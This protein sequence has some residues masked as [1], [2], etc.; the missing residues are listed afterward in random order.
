VPGAGDGMSFSLGWA[1][2]LLGFVAALWAA[3]WLKPAA[4]V[5]VRFCAGAVVAFCLLMSAE[6]IW[7][8]D[9]LPLLSYVEYPW[10]MLQPAAL[11][12]A[13]LI[14]ALGPAFDA[15]PRYRRT[16]L[17][18][19]LALL[20]VPN[21]AHLQ[22]GR[23]A[24]PDLA[25]WT[26]AHMA[27]SGFETT[28]AGEI[29]PKWV[30]IVRGPASP[31]VAQVGGGD[32]EITDRV[33]TPFEWAGRVRAK[34]KSTVQIERTY[35]PGWT[36]QIDGRD[37]TPEPAQLTGRLQFAVEPGDHEVEV[38]WGRSPARRLGEGISLVAILIAAA[39]FRRR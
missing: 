21:V 11:C 20:I 37:A 31:R 32:A 17:A 12:L 38:A 9:N 29:T 34:T 33:S 19:A 36:V 2:I 10:R 23:T 8:W 27:A 3:R 7:F 35:Y 4:R 6:S 25:L 22:A 15:L 14:A 13:L 28:T 5:L 30:E 26:P 24:D 1:H 18:A 16:A 39:I